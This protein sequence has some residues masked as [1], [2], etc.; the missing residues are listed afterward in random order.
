MKK[1]YIFDLGRVLANFDLDIALRKFLKFSASY[2]NIEQMKSLIFDEKNKPIVINYESGKISPAD[3]YKQWSSLL[4]MNI[5]EEIFFD[6]WGSIFTEN[7]AFKKVLNLIKDSPKVILSNIDPI[8]WSIVSEFSVVKDYF[9]ISE[10]I[11][12]YNV[13]LRK[14][15]PKIYHLAIEKLGAV[16]EVI[17]FDDIDEYINFAKTLGIKAI[18]YDCR[19]NEID[20]IIKKV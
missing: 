2:K 18:Q 7:L 17:Y 10:C 3:F 8:H 19:Y 9:K 16:E 14:P 12:S 11:R 13:G 5:T 20:E 6:I 15:D 1:G 4:K